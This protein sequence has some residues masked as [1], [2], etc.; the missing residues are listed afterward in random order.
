MSASMYAY[1]VGLRNFNLGK[2]AAL[3]VI[4][5]IIV[6]GVS[7]TVNKVRAK[8]SA[9]AAAKLEMVAEEDFS[10]YDEAEVEA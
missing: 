6:L 8:K 1:Q 2:S 3:C 7:M 10:V 5:L 4:M 9:A